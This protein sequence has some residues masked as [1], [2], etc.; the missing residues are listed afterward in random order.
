[1][2]THK[3]SGR[4]LPPHSATPGV[5]RPALGLSVAT[6]V[7]AGLGYALLAT[8]LGRVL[9][10]T[11]AQGS[12][13]ERDGIIVGSTLVAQPFADARWFVPRPSAS[14]YDTTTLAGSNQARSNPELLAMIAGTR[15]RIAA[16]E[17]IDPTEVPADLA[18]R[19]GGGVDPHISPEGAHVQVARVAAARGLAPA[20]VQRRVDAH[21][22]APLFGLF[23][24]ARVNVLELN[25]ALDAQPA[26]AGAE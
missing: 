15:A 14:D 20:A 9:F 18:T 2:H 5:L 23:G 1:M 11:Q 13:V 16:R 10:P 17:G 8:G 25:L 7:F 22:R 24:A 21:T 26:P 3:T 12:L 19:S 6:L 4:T